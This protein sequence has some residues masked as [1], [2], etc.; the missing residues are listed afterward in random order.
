MT[1][2]E[3]ITKFKQLWGLA[4]PWTPVPSDDQ[5]IRWVGKF[6]DAAIEYAVVRVGNKSRH[7]CFQGHAA[8]RYMTSVLVNE[9]RSAGVGR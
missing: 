4:V 8:Y 7:A 1:S 9:A 6:D 3:R 2:F 5:I